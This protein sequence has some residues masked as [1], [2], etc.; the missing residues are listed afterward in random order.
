MQLI[1]MID[2]TKGPVTLREASQLG[3]G[4]PIDPETEPVVRA[5]LHVAASNEHLPPFLK[6]PPA[7]VLL[8]L[9]SQHLRGGAQPE[10][11][12][13]SLCQDPGSKA[14]TPTFLGCSVALISG[15]T[16]ACCPIQRCVHHVRYT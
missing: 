11:P 10:G 15:P 7:L 12:R 5:H 16:S 6:D 9:I 3:F 13:S 4:L 1:T 14:E 8:L 2:D